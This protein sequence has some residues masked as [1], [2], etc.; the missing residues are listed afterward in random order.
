MSFDF[1]ENEFK[2][3]G[4]CGLQMLDY[5]HGTLH[6]TFDLK[7]ENVW[8]P[9]NEKLFSLVPKRLMRAAVKDEIKRQTPES[10]ISKT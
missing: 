5:C 8:L 2:L 4:A 6:F 1:I 9:K 3:E 10:Q 7:I